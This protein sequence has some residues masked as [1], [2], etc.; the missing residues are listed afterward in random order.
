[1]ST[2]KMWLCASSAGMV[3]MA[4]ATAHAQ[5]AAGGPAANSAQAIPEI[6]VTGS[7]GGAS[8]KKLEAGYSI[9]TISPKA[10]QQLNIKSTGEILNA[11]PGVW[12][13]SSGGVGT[14]N[15]F[16]RGIPS[17]GDAPFVTIQI[18][19]MPVFGQQ[20][21]SFMD[22]TALFRADETISNVEAV[23]GGP[24]SVFADGEPGL[25]TNFSLKRGH[26]DTEGELK[27]TGTDY[28]DRRID[29]ELSGKL[30]DGL[31][32]M[33]GGYVADGPG[34]R[35]A[36]FDT[37]QGYQFTVNI[38]KD[39]DKGEFDIWARATNDHGEW[40][41]PFATTVPGLNLNT[42]N[43][44]NQYTRYAQIVNANGQS[45]TLDLGSG[46][47]WDGVIA[48]GKLEYDLGDGLELRDV[49]GVTSGEL[50]T[51]ALVGSGNAVTVAQVQAA[52][53][54]MGPV[55][56]LDTH[57]TLSGST[58]LQQYGAWMADKDLN[59][60]SNEVSLEKT[61]FNNKITAGYYFSRFSSAD[62][63]S[64]GNGRVM[65]V[66]GADDV[67]SVTNAEI[68]N[69][70]AAGAGDGNGPFFAMTDNGTDD[71][72]AVYVAD[73]F[74]VTDKLRIDL[75]GRYEDQKINFSINTLQ[76]STPTTTPTYALGTQ[77]VDRSRTTWTAAVNYAFSP[78]LDIYVRSSE[79]AHFPS[80]DDVRSEIGNGVPTV[81]D[82][83]T[84]YSDEGGLKF[85]NHAVDADVTLFFD[86]VIGAVYND[87]GAPTT[88]AG[89]DTY[90]VEFYGRWTSD[91]GLS[92]TTDD[93][94]E[95]PIT[96]TPAIPAYNGKQAERIPKYQFRI[97]PAYQVKLTDDASA[98]FFLNFVAIGQRYGDLANTQALPAYQ[99][100][101]AGVIVN[102]NR[103]TFQLTGDNLTDSHGLTEGNPRVIG[104]GAASSLALSRPIFPTSATFSVGYRF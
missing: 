18:E 9:T 24:A 92:A 10:L 96:N 3:L 49:F 33:I 62:N 25:T 48:G 55:N 82:T 21:P 81:D 7:A 45:Q 47:G 5:A 101:A 54:G 22:Q 19:G 65:E 31:Y 12:V 56:T 63:W 13:E 2:R 15:V 102:Y 42:Y 11:V 88:I 1:M 78:H 98:N 58:Y 84:V 70:P 23:N 37:E 104:T 100:V 97:S 66:G 93:T 95:N 57:Q 17:T 30:A 72:N 26:D 4:A 83:W 76:G 60:I 90:G 99:T 53:P 40:Y 68:L 34:V 61:V 8:I 41:V 50:D 28:G 51:R 103:L 79:G 64:L 89:S 35:S 44:L 77:N 6:V 14:S 46:R 52:N 74:S 43:P 91:F 67:T 75:G 29:G 69:T 36:G 27:V 20:S 38:T 16:V 86:K 59:Y 94:L 71:L 87:V 85:H 80:F 39:L 32:Y 73:S